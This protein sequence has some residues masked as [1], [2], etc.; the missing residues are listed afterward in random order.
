MSLAILQELKALA[1]PDQARILQRFFK[2][3]K[4]EYG[5]GDVFLGIRMPALRA[6]SK[7]YEIPPLIELRTLLDSRYHEARMLALLFLM[8][9]YRASHDDTTRKEVVDFY[10]ANT[11]RINNWDLVDISC[12]DIVG[13]HLLDKSRK[14]LYRL[15]KSK[16]LW[17]QR[18][19]IISTWTFIKHHEFD[20]TL[21]LSEKL[22][23]HPH[24]LMHKAV[25]W[26]LREVG[27]KNPA[28]LRAFL[29]QHRLQMPRTMLR[30]AIEHFPEKTRKIYLA[31]R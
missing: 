3:G 8:R 14:L 22:L 20:D 25:G 12:R 26:M 29:D 10:L 28:V 19:A 17:E 16:N 30:Y 5:E 31:R 1:D 13:V 9:S 27:K 18:I 2:T 21:A 15:A 6:L 7:K 24:D 4:G 23:T 11:A